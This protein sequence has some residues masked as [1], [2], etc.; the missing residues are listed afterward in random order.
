MLV[1][2]FP[3]LCSC[4]C[5]LVCPLSS[6]IVLHGL[7]GLSS[8]LFYFLVFFLDFSLPA[9][10]I[11]GLL[12]LDTLLIKLTSCS[13]TYPPLCVLH[14]SPCFHKPSH[15]FHSD[16]FT[17]QTS[18][19]HKCSYPTLGKQ[20]SKKKKKKM[21]VFS[22]MLNRSFNRNLSKAEMM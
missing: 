12:R 16:M 11:F 13:F 19:W 22:Q 17:L 10:W 7:S 15:Q 21:S 4:S 2:L 3:S 20:A 9:F 8:V 14:L 5:S 6:L 18:E 1:C